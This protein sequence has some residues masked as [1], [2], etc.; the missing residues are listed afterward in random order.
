MTELNGLDETELAEQEHK[1]LLEMVSAHDAYDALFTSKGRPVLDG[2][3]VPELNLDISEVRAAQRRWY[4]AMKN[5]NK[6]RRKRRIAELPLGP[7]PEQ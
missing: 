7:E 4:D 2:S 3:K 6:I 5:L 1:A